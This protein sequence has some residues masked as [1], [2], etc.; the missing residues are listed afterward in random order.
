MF[1][2]QSSKLRFKVQS[3]VFSRGVAEVADEAVE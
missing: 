1:K 2:V 3:L